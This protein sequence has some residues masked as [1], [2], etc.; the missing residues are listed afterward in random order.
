MKKS[1]IL[2]EGATRKEIKVKKIHSFPV[3]NINIIKCIG[4]KSC[5]VRVRKHVSIILANEGF[6]WNMSAMLSA[7]RY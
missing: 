3:V 6:L 7:T 1:P 2:Y 4:I 5:I